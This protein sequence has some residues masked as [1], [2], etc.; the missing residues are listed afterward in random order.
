M[1]RTINMKNTNILLGHGSGAGLTRHL[2]ENIFNK[3]FAME[4]LTDAMDIG[5]NMVIS[6]DCHVIYPLFFPGG[7]IGKLSVTGTINDVSVQGATPL[8]L[9]AGFIIEEGFPISQL[10]KIVI[11]MQKTAAAAHVK[12]IGGDTKVVQKGKADGIY[13][14]TTGVGQ[15]PAGISLK[16]QNICVGD[17]VIVS[18]TLADHSVAIINAREDMQLDPP[19]V[20]DCAS[21][22]ELCHK[23]RAY[24]GMRMMRDA[25]RGGVA[26]ILNE[27]S[28]ETNI[29]L[30]IE[31][32][33]IPVKENIQAICDMLGLDPLYMANEGKLICVVG[34][35]AEAVLADMQAHP[36][37]KDARIIGKVVTGEQGVYLRTS[38]GGLRPMLMQESD[39]LPRIC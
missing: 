11:S 15:I 31:E 37:G 10:E 17:S 35:D 25:T 26:T 32:A 39:P 36:L 23:I 38:I 19:P 30:I 8:Y 24:P 9:V 34:A 13:I 33:Q 2:I 22:H 27:I 16:T 3:H 4:A 29:Q 1:L 14:T 18:G 21:L 28:E 5:H 20:S 12:I 6:T 7:D